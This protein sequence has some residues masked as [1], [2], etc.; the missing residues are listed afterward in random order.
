ME[1]FYFGRQ[2]RLLG[3]RSEAQGHRRKTGVLICPSLAME[4]LRSYR[5]LFLFSE[6]LAARGFETMRFD[7]SCTGDSSGETHEANVDHWIDDIA[8]ACREL[9]ELSGCTRVCLLGLRIGGL[10][11]AA[12]MKKG[13]R[14]E[15]M[16]LWDPPAAGTEWLRQLR[17]L[18][19]S[20]YARKNLY[21]HRK[22]IIPASRNQLLGMP[23]EPE[24]ASNI[25]RLQ[26]PDAAAQD[27]IIV[28]SSRDHV[29]PQG[30]RSV[31]LPDDANWT[32]TAWIN[33]PW[34]PPAS[35][36]TLLDHMEH[37]LQ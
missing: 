7:Y 28:A 24:L 32:S 34:A 4:Y 21:R 12:A 11:A 36:S 13:L 31:A 30:F 10:L 2:R 20:H 9:R 26:L 33:T 19:R 5:G 8:T 16:L 23:I 3:A 14:A 17:D 6:Q 29:T 15:A 27:F 1:L 25:E 35:F 37:W 18:D 22:S